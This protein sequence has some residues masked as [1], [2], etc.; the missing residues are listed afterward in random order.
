MPGIPSQPNNIPL[1]SSLPKVSFRKIPPDE[2]LLFHIPPGIIDPHALP[3]GYNDGAEYVKPHHYIRYVEPAEGDLKRQVEYD[4][5]EQDQEWLDALNQERRK[6]GLDTISYETFEIILDQLEK[7]WFDLMTRV[8]PKV[9]PGAAAAD[10]AAG[11][12]DDDADSEGGEDSKCAICDDGEAENSNAIVFCDGCNLAVHQDCYGIP[13]IP[14]GQWLCRKCTVS[15]DRAVSCLLCPHEGGA[16]K[17][18]T[19]GKWAHLLCAMWVPETGVSNPVYMEPIDSVER[20]PKARWK[21]QCYLCRHRMGACIQCDNRSCFTAFHVTCARK[22]GL[23]FRTE[24]TRVSRHLYDDSDDSD[25]DG[26]EV[27]RACCHR[28]MPLQMRHQLKIDFGRQGAADDDRPDTPHRASPFAASRTREQS[29]ESGVGAPLISVSRRSSI[30]GGSDNRASTSEPR[31]SSKSARAYKKS[32]KVGPPLVPAYIANRVL[33][34]MSKI[35]LR[36]K[37]TAVQLIARYWSLKREARRGAPLLKRLHLEPWTASSQN[38]EQTDAQKIKKLHFLRSVREDLERVRMLVEQVR[39]RE[40]EKL[41][42]AHEIRDS[43]VEPVLFPFHADLRAA[44]AKFEAVDR[45]GFFA[46][47]VS[48][49]DV[50]DYY[51]IVKEPMDW[52]AIK[53]KIANIEYECVEEMRTDVLK[54]TTNAMTYNKPDTPYHKAATKILKMIPDVFDELA[55]IES[56]H[57]RFHQQRLQQEQAGTED[58][59]LAATAPQ[60]DAETR[61]H[62]LEL[63]IEPPSV[64]L[65]LLRDYAEMDDEEQ[66]ELRQQAYGS[67]PVP[68]PVVKQ[69][70]DDA[71]AELTDAAIIP[72]VANLVQDFVQQIYVSP[73]PPPSAEPTTSSA[74][75]GE[76]SAS[77]TKSGAS[78]RNTA[79]SKPERKRKTSDTPAAPVA[80][81]RST[82]RAPAADEIAGAEASA[83]AAPPSASGRKLRQRA[84]SGGSAASPD[85]SAEAAA[86]ATAMGKTQSQTSAKSK[87]GVQVQEDVGAHDSFLLFNTGWVLPEGSK[88][89]RAGAARP[90]MIGQRPRKISAPESP[91]AAAPSALP[92]GGSGSTPQRPRSRTVPSSHPQPGHVAAIKTKPHGRQRNAAGKKVEAEDVAAGEGGPAASSP[93]TSDDEAPDEAATS[94]PEGGNERRSKRTRQEETTAAKE[95]ASGSTRRSTRAGDA[96]AERSAS[97]PRKRLRGGAAR[98][99]SPVRDYSSTSLPENGAKVWAKIE[100][101]PHFPAVV[102]TDERQIPASVLRNRPDTPHTVAVEFYGRPR[103]WGWVAPSK[104][105]PLVFDEADAARFFKMAARKGQLNKV[106]EAY[107]EAFTRSKR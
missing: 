97:P 23:L 29:V 105:A 100:T 20:I 93:L 46:L 98:S 47:P 10:A 43:L 19:T 85:P 55:N 107:D 51:E 22:A 104:L 52:A 99:T 79:A 36:K 60:I 2:S 58:G 39:K 76:A 101:F 87:D 18:T 75:A 84:Q 13:Y 53:Q 12:H 62:L 34:Y 26:S 54:I 41:R 9:R 4:M 35:H 81:R 103:S 86:T 57:L 33:E 106:K 38:K 94:A 102:V 78:S 73:P 67:I 28:H 65:S 15:P 21:L 59:T 44:V 77:K 82:R 63:G 91:S 50:P 3:F 48:K 7:E 37:A 66:A 72:P 42:Q 92:D 27:L 61:R 8:P 89:H 14:E 80:E 5:D 96:S 45:H 25:E 30:V 49:L 17:Q 32:F 95:D 31:N 70:H 71:R 1:A 40:R 83:P 64:I 68:A 6:D 74:E 88:R 16:F 56:S 11:T 69:E 24:R 90:E